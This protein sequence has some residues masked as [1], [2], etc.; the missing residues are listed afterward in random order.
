M[1]KTIKK[2]IENL[3]SKPGVY[4]FKDQNGGILYA[5]KAVN[6]KK[7]VAS[8][9]SKTVQSGFNQ[10][11]IPLVFEIDFIRTKNAKEA[12]ILE[13][14]MI[15]KYQPR[16]NIQWRDD[17]S[18]LWVEITH[19]EWPKIKIIHK[20]QLAIGDTRL[21][22]IGPFVNATELK[23]VLRTLRK[24]LPFR[25]CKNSYEKPCLQWHLGLCPAHDSCISPI[26]YRQLLNTLVQILRLYAGEALRVEAY[27]I[28]NIQ[29]NFAAGSMV[30]FKGTRPKKS[31]YRKFRIKTVLGA[32]DPAMIREILERRLKHK[33]W[34]YPDLILIDGGRTQ[35]N[36][37]RLS[38]RFAAGPLRFVEGEASNKQSAII[39]LAKREDEIYTEF[40]PRALKIKKLPI[41]L[42][43]VF[44]AIRDEAH[45]F[46]ISY[47]RKLHRKNLKNHEK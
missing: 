12:L 26:A 35:L 32:N 19:D 29:G 43:L 5:G 44:Q 8:H 28:S 42:R 36:A 18:Y 46:A 23:N 40:S 21:A 7:R 2:Q 39:A 3:P 15:K 22:T 11:F 6:L 10:Y 30:V 4:F 17:K 14:Q 33:E 38:L 13:D 31:D 41:P 47:Y 9:F 16:F 37:A 24:V 20:K 34:P 45:R 25:T 1:L 27:D